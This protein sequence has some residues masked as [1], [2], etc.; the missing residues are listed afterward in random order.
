MSANKKENLKI[1]NQI[2]KRVHFLLNQM[3][4]TAN[5]RPDQQKGDPKVGGH[6]SASVSSLHI[7]GAL[8]LAV[9]SGFDVLAHKPHT[10]PTD[11]AYNYL[12]DLFLDEH[13]QPLSPSKAEQAMRGLRAFPKENEFVF[14][15]YHSVYDPDHHNF[16]PSGTVGIPPV[17][18]GYLALAYKAL[19]LQ[20]Y[21]T[22]KAH[23]WALIGD[24]E[25]REGSLMEAVPDLAER[26]VGNLTWILDY[27]RQSLDGHRLINENIMEGS[28]SDR[29]RKTLL[30]NGWEVI[31]VKHGS[32][33]QKMFQKPG[34]KQFQNFLE[35]EL[36]DTAFQSL[37]NTSGKTLR[38]F[39]SKNK[40]LESFLKN[41]SDEEIKRAVTDLGGH[42][43]EVLISSLEDSKKNSKKPCL[44]LAHTIKGWGLEM[45]G[46]SGNHSYMVSKK[47][48]EILR[49]K[50]CN[51]S[52]K[53][54]PRFSKGSAEDIFLKNRKEVLY[55]D[56]L[57]QRKIKEENTKKFK[58]T[59]SD[60][61]SLDLN[62]DF[63]KMS[64][65]HTQWFLGQ[66]L[67]KFSRIAGSEKS[68]LKPEEQE[69]KPPAELIYSMSP[70]V[71]TST[72]L[73]G[74]MNEKTLGPA[75][76]TDED[77]KKG[78]EDKKSPDLITQSQPDN[79]FIRFEIVEANCIS[80][81]SAFGKARDILGAPLLPIMTVYDFFIK[82]A[83]D[84][85]FYALYW[86]SSFILFGTP[87]GVTLSPE[88][89]QH[90]WKSDFQIPNQI[91]WEPFFLQ[92]LNWILSD[93]VHRHFTWN[94]KERTG[95]L[96]R[97]VT[98][99]V[100]QKQFLK[101][102]KTQKRF[103]Q[104]T[105][106]LILPDKLSVDNTQ[107]NTE[108]VTE[109]YS[110]IKKESTLACVSDEKIFQQIKKETL[111]GAYFFLNYKGYAD[112][113]EEDNVV[114]L[115]AMGALGASALSASQE[116]LNQGIYANVVIVTS[117]DL[118]LGGLAEKNN[119]FHLRKTLSLENNLAPV[120]SVHDGEPGLLDNIGS[121]LG[122]HQET[123]AVR[124]H[125]LCG[126]PADVYKYHKID[127]DSVVTA[128]L[129]ALI[130]QSEKFFLNK[131]D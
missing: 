22:P 103:K 7:L 40:N 72:N 17:V 112:Y 62:I 48:I 15:S 42:D 75:I 90:G 61:S 126:R 66:A 20:G 64:W 93:A 1:F 118:L 18:L 92:E 88:G 131:V 26:E 85:Y 33:R 110:E 4:Y 41:V 39:L 108:T 78:L 3:I 125:S 44:I 107:S 117:P 115:F 38:S 63:Q 67:S 81:M 74:A 12:L 2:A 130:R 30:A 6:P 59:F 31:E 70:D 32:F 19:K 77:I 23:F 5:H 53:E 29:I 13:L 127:K 94:N 109:N 102:L 45:S 28:D 97:A 80:C 119:Y 71:G 69:L 120:V 51:N 65:P 123:L 57:A 43:F 34:G 100:D 95:V 83:L 82:R 35:N 101:Y 124:K 16:L 121:I 87:S 91:T 79:R 37:L 122:V 104:D 114:H 24:S 89:A 55:K 52:D 49:Q 46:L 54:F 36:K 11:H 21:K 96:I 68:S 128:S 50:L 129:K 27:N 58:Q 86:N 56:I 60:S 47:E 99:G 84:Q 9:K 116:L 73:S 106:A 25:F 111:S 76:I 14:Q 8:H 10:S 105:K 113:I 98:K